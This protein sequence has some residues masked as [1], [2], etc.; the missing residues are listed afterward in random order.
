MSAHTPVIAPDRSQ[1][2]VDIA[3]PGAAG[4]WRLRAPENAVDD[5]GFVRRFDPAPAPKWRVGPRGLDCQIA[6]CPPG[7]NITRRVPPV[8]LH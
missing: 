5:R 2:A 6:V 1:P 4:I 3:L 7:R 8:L